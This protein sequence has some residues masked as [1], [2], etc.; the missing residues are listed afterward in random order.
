[1]NNEGNYYQNK[2]FVDLT[3]QALI[4]TLLIILAPC[5]KPDLM[6]FDLPDSINYGHHCI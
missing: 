6:K 5:P 1:M 3:A 2:A 4:L